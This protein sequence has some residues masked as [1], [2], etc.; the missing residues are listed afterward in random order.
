MRGA[1]R[2]FTRP[3]S[4]A[5]WIA[6]SHR[7]KEVRES[8]DKHLRA[9]GIARPATENDAKRLLKLRLKQTGADSLGAKAF[10]GPQQ[11]RVLVGELLNAL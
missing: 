6:Y 3:N 9:S 1:G 8:V 2:I 10:V 4:S 7:G 5:I 11:E